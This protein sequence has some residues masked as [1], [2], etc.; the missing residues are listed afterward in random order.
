M[1]PYL[2]IK[3]E[4]TILLHPRGGR[5][6]PAHVFESAAIHAVNAALGAGR[7]LLVRGEPGTGKSQLARAVAQQLGRAFVHRVVDIRTEARDLCFSLDGVARLAKAQLLGA[8]QERDLAKLKSLLH[9]R[10][11]VE[12]GALWWAFDWDSAAQ[13]ATAASDIDAAIPDRP[14][15][16]R[17]ADGCVLLIDEIDKADSSLPN[18]LLEALGDGEFAVPAGCGD[19]GRVRVSGA[20]PLVVVTTNE[21]RAL[22]DAFLRRCLVLPLRLPEGRAELRSW[23]VARGRAHCQVYEGGGNGGVIHGVLQAAADLLIED[24]ELMQG[25]GLS[26]PGQAEYLDLVRTVFEQARQRGVDPGQVLA[27]SAPFALRKHPQ[28]PPL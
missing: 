28:E 12:P 15:G 6:Q 18:G 19:Q 25:S 27:W 1:P 13:Q 22:P 5:P 26:A 16:W 7:P 4:T 11:F 24:R 9:P 23:L 10:Y 20:W 21:E 2:E 3:P 17:P 14:D 8:A